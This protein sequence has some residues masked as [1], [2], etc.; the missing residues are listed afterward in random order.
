MIGLTVIA[1]GTSLPELAATLISALRNEH[2]IAIG[3]IVGSNIFNL[4]AVLGL[5]GLIR[6]VAV[7]HAV[8]TRDYPAMAGL[9]VLLF[10]M[11]YGF[12]GPARLTRLDGALLLVAFGAYETLLYFGELH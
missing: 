7:D 8:L 3:N 10:V 2:D 6:P 1:L 12:T 5:P 4:L 9:T 11:A